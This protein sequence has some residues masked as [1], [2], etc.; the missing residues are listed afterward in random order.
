MKKIV[1]FSILSI[2]F[3]LSCT[4]QEKTRCP[5]FIETEAKDYANYYINIIEGMVPEMDTINLYSKAKNPLARLTSLDDALLEK[6]EV[7]WKRVDGGT[8]NPK[9]FTLYWTVTIPAGGTATLN[10][11]PLMRAEQLLEM[12]FLQLLPENGG[13]DKETGNNF[14]I[15]EGQI[16]FY[17][18]TV[19]GCDIVAGPMNVTFEFYYYG[20]GK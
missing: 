17:C 12:P 6:I 4:D 7:I 2:L 10:N 8:I 9:P 11:V 15:C 5:I 14:I 13:I 19:Q 20:G 16:Y 1:I 3:L 18:R